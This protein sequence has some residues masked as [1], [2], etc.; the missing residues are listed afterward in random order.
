MNLDERIKDK[1]V[2][3]AK[4]YSNIKQVVLFGS[5][6][7]GDNSSNSD[8]DLGIYMMNDYNKLKFGLF[9]SEIDNIDT[10]LKFDLVI[11]DSGLSSKMI[12]NITKE[13]VCLMNRF[14]QKYENYKN[15]LERLKESVVEFEKTKSLTVRD[16]VIQ[17]F[18]F[19]MD[20]AW[21][22]IR[23]FLI[24]QGFT[25]LNSPKSVLKQAYSYG[26]LKDEEVWLNIVN[27]R[28]NTSHLYK[29]EMAN[30]VFG[31]IHE[32]YIAAFNSLILEMDKN[33]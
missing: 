24:E 12:E 6:A 4:K 9:C 5:R 14:S 8:I 25:E 21:K 1:I 30:E 19:T 28:N 29:E 15:A 20:L 22:T 3:I 7:R 17:R 18:E 27:D 16:G 26:L 23:E 32:N 13:G 2:T 33:I 10:L 31:H 11:V